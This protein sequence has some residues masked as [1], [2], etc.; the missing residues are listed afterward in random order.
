MK[1]RTAWI[2]VTLGCLWVSQ[3]YAEESPVVPKQAWSFSSLVGTFDRGALQRGFQV[4]KEVCAACHGLQYVRF[5][6]LEALGFTK[7]EIKAIAASYSIQDGPNEEGEV[8]ERPGRSSDA[9][10]SPYKN[11]NASR[12]ANHGAYPPDLSLMVKARADGAN[13]LYALLTG[14]QPPPKGF[15]LG[16][17]MHYNAYFPGYQI[18]MAPPLSDGLVTF[19]D[20][21]PSTVPQMAKDVTT[22][23][24][25][26]AEPELEKRREIGFKVL[27]FLSVF[28]GLLFWMMRRIWKQRPA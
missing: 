9:M 10:P 27:F 24:A 22:F 14:F 19:A 20:G 12:A 26:T 15:G 6:E 4:Y 3:G 28:T 17:N 25:W 18:A 23:L 5:R 16:E 21:S 1:L 2:G 7:Q 13:Y 8:F 11:E